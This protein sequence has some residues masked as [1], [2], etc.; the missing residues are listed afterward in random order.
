MDV[1]RKGASRNRMIRRIIYASIV[2]VAVPLIV[3]AFAVEACR[4]SSG[5][6]DG[7]DRYGEA[8]SHAS[9]GSRPGHPGTRGCG[10]PAQTIGRVDQ[11][12]VRPGVVQPDTVLIKMSNRSWNSPPRPP[13]GR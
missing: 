7:L 12:V 10:V 2:V 4:S 3:G 13:S 5:T 9:T 11:I 8:R 1:P 6:R